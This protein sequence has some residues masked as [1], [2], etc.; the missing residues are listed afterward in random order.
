MAVFRRF[1]AVGSG[2]LEGR[3]WKGGRK[4]LISLGFRGRVVIFAGSW[5]TP[6]AGGS[7]TAAARR[8]Q[9]PRWMV[10][11]NR[12]SARGIAPFRAAAWLE[13]AGTDK[14]QDLD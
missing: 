10:A 4:R 5:T 7:I 11:A 9:R 6:A 2:V 13:H 14:W 8:S 3:C 1:C 12:L